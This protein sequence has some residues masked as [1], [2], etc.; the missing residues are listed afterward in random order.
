MTRNI[1]SNIRKS[2]LLIGFRNRVG[3]RG[4]F[5]SFLAIL[6]LIIGYFLIKVP[7]TVASEPYPVMSR[8]AWAGL[9]LATAL[10]CIS[11][12]AVRKDNIAYGMAAFTKAAW[13]LRYI[14]LWYQGIAFAW[15]SAV[16]WICFSLT[17]LVIASWPEEI[18]RLPPEVMK[19]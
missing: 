13:G 7:V 16:V 3:R 1:K 14:Y 18:I 9:W 8:D 6:D 12:I 15:V 19:K 10:V 2:R 4:L 11:G 17:V 5:L